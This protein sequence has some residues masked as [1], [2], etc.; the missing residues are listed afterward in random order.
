MDLERENSIR[1]VTLV[2]SAVNLLL[3]A[4]KFMAGILGNSS[5]MIADAAH[6]LSDFASDVIVLLCLRVS[7]KPEDEDH[8][9]GHGKFETLASIAIGLILLATGAG[10]FWEGLASV[11]E[12][13]RGGEL[14][15]P[16]WLAFAAALLSLAVKE[17]L[18]HY[19]VAAAKKFDSA[20]LKANAWHHRSDALS[21]I[22]TVIGIGGAMLPG[23]A[24]RI[25][26]PLA[27]CLISVFI[28]LMAFSLMKPGIDELMEKSLPD[29][30]REAIR[31]SIAS[32][33][34]V[35]GYHRIRTRRMG[36]NRAVEAHIKLAADLPL[37]E[38]H[39][40]ATA[41]EKKIQ[42]A[43]GKNTHVGI[44]MEPAAGTEKRK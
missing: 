31:Q 6:S 20:T 40:I 12:F 19:T 14:A 8:A 16:T 41:V 27:A 15:T 3:V 28:I 38:A 35:L 7:G 21:S 43:L 23:E 9:Y 25:L 22:A 42:A 17:G 33:P 10:L 4:F 24:W 1:R 34:G 37:R 2:G 44:H 36:V 30:E 39:D 18:Y 5:A 13:A 11:I 32:T 26:D 29:A